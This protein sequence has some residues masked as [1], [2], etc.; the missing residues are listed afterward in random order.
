MKYNMKTY[1]SGDLQL[2]EIDE[3]ETI[4]EQCEFKYR[5]TKDELGW[6]DF[7][8][9]R[10]AISAYFLENTTLTLDPETNGIALIDILGV[11]A[12]LDADG[13]DRAPCLSE[14]TQLQR[15]LWFIGC[16]SLSF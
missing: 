7:I 2:L 9:D 12:A 1:T 10:Y 11:S 4:T 13:V 14:D 16:N 15:L 8:G 5:L 6:L 3:F